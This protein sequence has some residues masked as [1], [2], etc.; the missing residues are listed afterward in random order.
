LGRWVV[1]IN[2]EGR[3]WVTSGRKTGGVESFLG[4]STGGS[5]GSGSI[6]GTEAAEYSASREQKRGQ[7]FGTLMTKKGSKRARAQEGSAVVLSKQ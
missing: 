2:R 4:E 5:A 7:S 1:P 6:V 3:A